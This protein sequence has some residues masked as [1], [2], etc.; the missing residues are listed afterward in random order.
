MSQCRMHNK[1]ESVYKIFEGM[2]AKLNALLLYFCLR[3]NKY[4]YSMHYQ[5]FVLHKSG[6]SHYLT[7]GILPSV[8][9]TSS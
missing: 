3:G 8:I 6:Q 7:L 5:L 4:C 1:I 9:I 2:H